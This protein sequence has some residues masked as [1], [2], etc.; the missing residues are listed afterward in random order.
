[1]EAG[2]SPSAYPMTLNASEKLPKPSFFT[3]AESYLEKYKPA[4]MSF[5]LVA[6]RCGFGGTSPTLLLAPRQGRRESVSGSVLRFAAPVQN[7]RGYNGAKAIKGMDSPTSAERS[8]LMFHE[9]FQRFLADR[10]KEYYSRQRL[11][12]VFNPAMSAWQLVHEILESARA[13]GKEGPVAQYLAGAAL[14]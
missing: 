7:C 6:I 13:A 9:T 5:S 3:P 10:L 8:E 11:S 1:M 4:R 2:F 14:Q 12:L